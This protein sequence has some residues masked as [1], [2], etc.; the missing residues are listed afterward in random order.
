MAGK[1]RCSAGSPADI[2]K[3]VAVRLGYQAYRVY[4]ELRPP[5]GPLLAA[6]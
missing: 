2:V 6:Q 5:L 4:H 1:P 3:A